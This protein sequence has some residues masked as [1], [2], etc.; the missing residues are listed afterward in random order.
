MTIFCHKISLLWYILWQYF[1][2][3][4]LERIN[5]TNSFI[6][7]IIKYLVFLYLSKSR[8]LNVALE[9]FIC[10]LKYTFLYC[11]QYANLR[12]LENISNA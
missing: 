5:Q 11:L 9:S 2:N 6:D 7:I 3:Y 10:V 8:Y 4:I 1:E 12:N